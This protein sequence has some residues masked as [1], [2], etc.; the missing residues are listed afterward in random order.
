[1]KD[2]TSEIPKFSK[3]IKILEV[4]DVGH[5]DNVNVTTKQ[6]L[7]NTLS[8][9]QTITDLETKAGAME[10]YHEGAAYHAGEYCLYH[11]ELYRC[12]QDT[13][14]P[15]DEVCWKRTDTLEEIGSLNKELSKL[16]RPEFDDSGEVEGITSFTNFL[17]SIVSK[18]PIITF[19]RNFKAG[20]KFVLHAG[21]LVTDC[22]TDRDDLPAAACTVK[23]LMD[24]Y[25]QLNSDMGTYYSLAEAIVIPIG[26][27]LNDYYEFGNYVSM[28]GDITG[29]ITDTLLNCPYKGC[30]FMLHV[31]RVTSSASNRNFA[32]QRII[33]HHSESIEYWRVKS[34]GT[35][36]KWYQ[37]K[38]TLV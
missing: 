14:G 27:D 5:A 4:S 32:K 7:E 24:L 3:S 34:G 22:V 6:L 12:I 16:E 28:T 25:T 23:D 33:L 1:M 26:A 31:E 30:G 15:W 17:N 37:V 13:E 9:R 10:E 36:R 35:W 29:D 20:M 38:G 18:M 11:N 8:N 19:F 21:Q 2:Y